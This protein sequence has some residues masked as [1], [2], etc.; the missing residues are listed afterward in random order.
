MYVVQI[1]LD[2]LAILSIENEKARNF[3]VKMIESLKNA[4]STLFKS[5]FFIL[6]IY[7]VFCLNVQIYFVTNIYAVNSSNNNLFIKGLFTLYFSLC[8]YNLYGL[9]LCSYT[10]DSIIL[11][12]YKL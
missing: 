12:C 9:K 11:L 7:F 1:R 8:T 3:N 10:T 6:L 5:Q 2:Y 4:L